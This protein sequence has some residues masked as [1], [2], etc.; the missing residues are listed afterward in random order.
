MNGTPSQHQEGYDFT[1]S[2]VE[3]TPPAITEV[4]YPENLDGLRLHYWCSPPREFVKVRAS[5]ASGIQRIKVDGNLTAIGF[6]SDENGPLLMLDYPN[7]SPDRTTFF[8][9]SQE[10]TESPCVVNFEGFSDNY[11]EFTK[12]DLDFS[13][14]VCDGAGNSVS[15]SYHK[16]YTPEGDLEIVSVEPVQVV[17]GAPLVNKKATAFRVKVNSHFNYPVETKFRLE[18]PDATWYKAP[19]E[20]IS[21]GEEGPPEVWGPI[22]IPAGARNYEIM[23]PIIPDWQKDQD[24]SLSN[25]AGV[26]S[27]SWFGE[28]VPD[29]RSVPRPKADSVSFTV[30]IDPDREIT[31]TD[32]GNNRMASGFYG[33]ISTKPWR[34]LV[35]PTKGGEFG[36][37][38]PTIAS[39]QPSVKRQIEYLLA[40]FPIADSKISY[41]IKALIW[42][43]GTYGYSTYCGDNEDRGAFQR[44]IAREAKDAGYDFGIAIG[45]GGGGGASGQDAVNVGIDAGNEVLAHEFNHQVTGMGDIYSYRH[46]D[47]A[48]PYCEYGSTWDNCPDGYSW[49]QCQS[50]CTGQGGKLYG[51]P[52]TRN[53]VPASDGFWVNRWIPISSQTSAYIMDGC[54]QS[55]SCTWRWMRLEDIRTCVGRGECGHRLPDGT[56]AWGD[57]GHGI[58]APGIDNDGYLNLLE[59]DRF[60]SEADPEALL[61]S[62]TINKNGTATFDPFIYL[63]NA[64]LDIA[65]GEEGDYHFVLLDERGNVLS[66]SGFAV[67]FYMPD[68]AGGPVDEVSF[69]YRIEWKEGTKRIELQ[70]KS[71]KVLASREVSPNKPEIKVLYPD[72][73]EVFAKGEKIEIKWEASDKDEDVLTYSLAISMNNGETWLPVDIDIKGNEY[74]LNTIGLE[75]GENYLIKVRATDGVNTDEDVSDNTFSVALEA[76]KAKGFPTQYLVIGA[77]IAIII[78]LAVAYL[79][80]RRKNEE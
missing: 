12:I 70:D 67:S 2:P 31:E 54:I 36:N 55:G 20:G 19:P 63:P 42:R 50:W 49:G 46:C 43:D 14:S 59:S 57:I 15:R 4:S 78:L 22:K 33:V 40:V 21:F 13:V 66:K 28:N 16:T 30:E 23:L 71:G 60:V 37:C 53:V 68:P 58:D 44:R 62:G 11:P 64:T 77:I 18:L 65:P 52:D 34:F 10:C 35:F 38:A 39:I 29:T 1:F 27:R 48:V 79:L 73:G 72:G 69:V 76:E 8:N 7:P 9:I 74:D 25:P 41:D 32:E 47:W 3:L 24:V 6:I 45:C 61:V 56:I 51:C 75:E 80:R 17:Y 26:I 5:D